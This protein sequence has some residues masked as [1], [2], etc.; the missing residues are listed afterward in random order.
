M[1][2]LELLIAGEDVQATGGRTFTRENPLTG[3]TAT[4]AAA[5]SVT[6]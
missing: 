4:V 5:A 6:P 3:E 2:M 1:G